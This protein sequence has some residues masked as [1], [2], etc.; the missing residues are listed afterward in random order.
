VPCRTLS[1]QRQA[2][3]VTKEGTSRSP[4]NQ[5][6]PGHRHPAPGSGEATAAVAVLAGALALAC[7]QG[8]VPVFADE[9]AP[10]AALLGRLVAAQRAGQAAVRVPLGCLARLQRAFDAGNACADP[11][12]TVPAAVPGLVEPLTSRELEVLELLAAGSRTRPSRG[13][14]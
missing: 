9:G 7:P 4:W 12:K 3:P 11:G 5:A 10:M 2:V 6:R 13:N 1:D 8:H 14:W